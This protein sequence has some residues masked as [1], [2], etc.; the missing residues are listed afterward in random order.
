M[1]DS[2]RPSST[3]TRSHL[4][5]YIALCLIWGSTWLAIHI[6][7]SDV[8]P[9]E[10]AAVRFLLAAFL[11]LALAAFQKRP[12]PKGESQWSAIVVLA[13]T[14]LAVP[15]GLIFWAEQYVT[16]SMT[17]VLFS[18]MPLVVALLTPLMTHRTVPRS[19]VF[20]LVV[21]F[22]SL[23]WLFYAELRVSPRA[24]L[25]GSAVLLA[26][27][28]SSWSVVF[29]KNRLHEIDSVVATGLQFLFGAVA[30]F[31]GTWALEARRHAVWTRPAIVAMVFLTV[32]GS[33]AAFVVYY[34]LL[35]RMQPYQLAT[36]SLVVPVVAVLEGAFFREQI[37]LTMV[38]VIII[39][40]ASVG[41]VLRAEAGAGSE[42]DFILLR[43]KTP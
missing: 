15:Y 8:P 6:V 38:I 2:G 11:L 24:L 30:L 40:L 18:A 3:L 4:L 27:V 14:I 39:V 22:A 9:L 31:W 33:C 26:V 13:I 37:P 34:W 41:T 12:W 7:V 5:G 10:A 43:G 19:A 36:T 42:E 28:V 17:A 23:L 16:S 29:A 35:K 32:F 20:A 25:G 21:A 1:T